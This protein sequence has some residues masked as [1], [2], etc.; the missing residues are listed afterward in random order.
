MEFL[1]NIDA[2]ITGIKDFIFNVGEFIIN[3]INLLPNEFKIV[4]VTLIIF[5]VGI[6]IYRFIR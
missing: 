2:T 6:L 3:Y 5:G 4:L 1:E